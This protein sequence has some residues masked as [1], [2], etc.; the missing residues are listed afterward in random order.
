MC[1][2]FTDDPVPA[3]VLD[4]V[5]A[6]AFRAPTA[7]N[8]DGLD[9][10]VLEGVDTARHWDLTLPPVRRDGFRWPG[11]LRAPVLIEVVV[12]PGAY[13]ERYGR[14]DKAASGLGD[15]VDAWD[16][17]FW[18]VDGGTA[19]MAMLLAAEAEGL[20]ALLFGLF[21]HER[22][23]LDAIGAPAGRRAVCTVALGR[24]ALGGRT[25][26]RSASAGRG[27]VAERI[28]TARW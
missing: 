28:H 11:L 7:G 23:V 20:G 18:F 22:A 10:V 13:V 14:E 19:V 5:L 24:P 9:L 21:G 25:P 15:G 8:T 6:A 12:D 3:D 1:R 16:V 26:S 4:R 27:E 2:D 17:P